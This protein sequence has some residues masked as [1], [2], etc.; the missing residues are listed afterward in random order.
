V[1][2]ELSY[3]GAKQMPTGSSFS[4]EQLR[5]RAHSLI[6]GGA[7]RVAICTHLYAGA[8]TG[9]PWD[10]CREPIKREHVEYEVRDPE[11]ANPLF[12]HLRC[13]QAWQRECIHRLTRNAAVQLRETMSQLGSDGV[14][15]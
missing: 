13:H 5:F 2:T 11:G 6:E 10:L 7:L 12:F 8:G 14:P 15:T 9:R 1:A 4:D 3:H